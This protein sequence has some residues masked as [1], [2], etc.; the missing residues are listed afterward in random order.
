MLVLSRKPGQE[1]VV[2]DE[3]TIVVLEIKALA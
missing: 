3:L 2:G 1:I